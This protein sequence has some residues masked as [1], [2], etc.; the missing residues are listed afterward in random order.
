MSF[1]TTSGAISEHCSIVSIQ[2]A[3]QQ[4][5][6]C[7]LVHVALCGGLVEDPIECKCLVLDS[8]ALRSNEGFR[9]FMNGVVFWRIE[10]P[11]ATLA[12]QVNRDS[13]SDLTNTCRQ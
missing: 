5:L 8:F 1:S 13:T 6:R 4:V 2:D 10:Y 7:R 12:F 11:I 9:E 3:V